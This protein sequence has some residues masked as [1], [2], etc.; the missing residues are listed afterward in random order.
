MEDSKIHLLDIRGSE[1]KKKRRRER[2]DRMMRRTE[3]IW[4]EP[5]SL[6]K[7]RPPSSFELPSRKIGRS[8][9]REGERALSP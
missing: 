3:G 8:K 6:A 9:G 1:K 2:K 5:N 4:K 7:T